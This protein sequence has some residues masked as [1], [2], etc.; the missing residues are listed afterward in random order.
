MIAIFYVSS[1]RRLLEAGYFHAISRSS[2]LTM[3]LVQLSDQ[4]IAEDRTGSLLRQM[5]EINN[6]Q[7]EVILLYTNRENIEL[8][9][10]QVIIIP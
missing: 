10:Q 5:E 3:N 2:K 9:L 8:M 1:E 7:P 6:L 4:E